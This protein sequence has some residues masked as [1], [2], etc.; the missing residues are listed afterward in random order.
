MVHGVVFLL[1][2]VYSFPF[3]V[4]TYIYIYTHVLFLSLG[5]HPF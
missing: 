3:F 4:G 2:V 1:A 5:G